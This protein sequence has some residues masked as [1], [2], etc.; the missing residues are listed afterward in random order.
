MSLRTFARAACNTIAYA[1]GTTETRELARGNLNKGLTLR[2]SGTFTM[3]L[4]VT[5]A[6]IRPGD[7]WAL[8]QRV[9]IEVNG[10][11]IRSLPGNVLRTLQREL[12]FGKPK[13]SAGWLPTATNLAVAFDSIVHIPYCLLG[14]ANPFDTLLDTRTLSTYRLRITWGTAT[15]VVAAA[16]AVTNTVNPVMEVYVGEIQP[17][18]SAKQVSYSTIAAKYTE[19]RTI[20]VSSG[21]KLGL[22][23]DRLYVGLLI[24]CKDA[25]NNDLA[26]AVKNIRLAAGN[27]IFRDLPF[28]V[29]RDLARLEGEI[30]QTA[31]AD[32]TLLRVDASTN[33]NSDAW[34][35][36]DLTAEGV[37][38][39]ALDT[40]G[41]SE[42]WLIL[43][44][45]AAVDKLCVVPLFLELP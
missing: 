36:L 2:L 37:Y 14:M 13:I 29:A 16:N 33:T 3:A 23:R 1:A 18:P 45:T 12:G 25:S 41:W 24:G 35:F 6:Q 31:L 39:E 28:G 26:G 7:E 5:A 4:A 34:C 21:Y 17:D 19:F 40:R 38:Q 44:T 11:V 9:E 22:E 27:A 42:F 20:P 15:D 43:E 32:G 8:I 10:A 30:D